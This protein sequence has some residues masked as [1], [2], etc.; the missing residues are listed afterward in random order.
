MTDTEKF[1]SLLLQPSFQLS[2]GEGVGGNK[3]G[4]P[5][6]KVATSII[7]RG[8]QTL[9]FLAVQNMQPRPLSEFA[10]QLNKN[11]F[12][13]AVSQARQLTEIDNLGQGE[14]RTCMILVVPNMQASQDPPGNPL[15]IDVAIKCSLDIWYFKMFFDLSAVLVADAR[16]P[17][18]QFQKSWAMLTPQKESSSVLDNLSP[19]VCTEVAA[20]GRKL[21][22]ANL[23]MVS[24]QSPAPGSHAVQLGGCTTNRL[25][26]FVQLQIAGSRAKITI[27]TDAPFLVPLMQTLLEK[28]LRALA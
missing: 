27:R 17:V 21:R 13:L 9:L 24:Q 28:Q 8:G 14:S 15:T 25:A 2:I 22:E 3:T 11:C 26:A 6:L 5:G 10:V 23:V 18:D 19:A 12:G 20:L 16:L 1:P 4:I 7:R